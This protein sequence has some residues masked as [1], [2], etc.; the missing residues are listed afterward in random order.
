VRTC[1]IAFLSL[2]LVAQSWTLAAQAPAPAKGVKF[3]TISQADLK[4][5]LTYLSSDELEGREVFTEGYGIAA[6]YIAERLRQFGVKPLGDDGTYFQVVKLRSYR[7]SRH[8]SVTVQVDGQSR[9]F[10]DGHHVAFPAAAGGRQ[11]LSFAG[12]DLVSVTT[13]TADS[14]L[15]GKLALRVDESSTAGA[16][17]VQELGAEASIAFVPSLTPST[18]AEEALAKLRDALDQASESLA[19]EQREAGRAGAA[20][21]LNGVLRRIHQA[22][23]YADIGPTPQRV[24]IPVRPRLTADGEFFGWLLSGAAVTLSELQGRVESG[25][26]LPPETFSRVRVTI[27]VDNAYEPVSTELTR[28]VVGM[29]QGSDPDLKST[30]VL[31]GAHLDHLGYAATDDDLRGRVQNPIESDKVWNGADDDGSGATAV[32][33]IA[34]AFAS[35]PKPKRSVVFVWHAGEEAGLYGSRYDADFPIVPLEKVECLLDIDMIGR[36]RD[37]DPSQGNTVYVIGDDRIST[38]LHNLVV[39]TNATLPVPLDLDYEYNDPADEN[40]FYTRSDHYSYASKGI[41]VAFFFTGTHPDYH[42]NSD[43]V[44][45]ILFNKEARIAQLVYQTGFA[46]ANS[47]DVLK[48]DFRGPRAGRLSHG[49]LN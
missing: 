13:S 29:V 26:P 5:W 14:N 2:A 30:Y 38:D 28:N 9:T 8:S 46:A 40:S 15:K 48:R 7:V 23:T 24:D 36:N 20:V 4:E 10:A 21:D 39:G 31:F 43:S 42:A 41:P 18:A 45:K 35:G 3:P 44:E 37:D 12:A 32:L 25:E 17:G 49:P 34:K 1:R 33:A 27:D 6:Q 19:A 22:G 11:T 16:A 47:E